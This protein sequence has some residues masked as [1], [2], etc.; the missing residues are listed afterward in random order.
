M[1]RHL[2]G[3]NWEGADIAA[4]SA[5]AARNVAC[6]L[7][8]FAGMIWRFDCVARRGSNI[9]FGID[10]VSWHFG[11][12]AARL[13]NDS[14]HFGD[15]S[16]CDGDDAL[17]FGDISRRFDEVAKGDVGDSWRQDGVAANLWECRRAG[18]RYEGP[19]SCDG[20]TG[21]GGKLS[22]ICPCAGY[23][24]VSLCANS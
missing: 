12:G 4:L 3:L 8:H 2:G 1:S 5:G 19:F 10:D 9:S 24:T 17:H 14:F 18:R 7:F 23:F 15:D 22:F 21:A 20:R 16:V 11:D 6:V 13:D